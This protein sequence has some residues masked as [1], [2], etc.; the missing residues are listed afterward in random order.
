MAQD[1]LLSRRGNPVSG[2][3]FW[4]RTDV[5]DALVLDLV[6]DRGSRCLFALRRIGKTSVL[7]EVERR[8]REYPGLT[9]IAIDAQG[10]GRF[11][12]FLAKLFEQIPTDSRFQ[13]ARQ[14]LAANGMLQ[15]LLPAAWARLTGTAGTAPAPGILNEFDHSA[16]WSGDIEH[17]LTEAGPIVLIV[18]ELPFMLRN[19]MRQDYKARDAERFLATL[20]SWRIGCGVRML[21][22]GSIGFSQLNR[23][24]GVQVA[25]HVGDVVPL[26]LPP[27]GEEDAVD[28]VDALARGQETQDWNRALSRAVVAASAETW[29]IFL[30]YGFDA[31]AK[32]PTRDPSRVRA[33]IGEGVRQALDE[34]FYKQFTTRLSRYGESERAARIV[35][36]TIMAN[37]PAATP[38]GAVDAALAAIEAVDSRDDLFEALREDDFI[39]FDTEGQTMGPASKLVPIWV[40]A[41][42]WGR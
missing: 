15:S 38:F 10:I 19:M 18:D 12:D 31:V 6:E 8:L 40:R 26:Q 3:D 35:L 13:T 24:D 36:R 5:V 11:K 16:A 39:H 23:I 22:S 14:R 37:A 20:R 25:D 9:V 21:L 41:R 33:I 7:L 1:R 30:Q 28:M 2:D 27:L 17:A 42:A 29:P 34:N 4:P 32:T